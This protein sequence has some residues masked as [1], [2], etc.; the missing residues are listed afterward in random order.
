MLLFWFSNSL[1]GALVFVVTHFL[2]ELGIPWM[3]AQSCKVRINLQSA[4]GLQ[5]IVVEGAGQIA[6]AGINFVLDGEYPGELEVIS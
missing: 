2:V 6:E 4:Y 1:R 5:L 3:F